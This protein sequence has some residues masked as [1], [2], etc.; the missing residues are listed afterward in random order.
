MAAMISW[1]SPKRRPVRA[2]TG[3]QF[4]F[5][6]AARSNIHGVIFNRWPVLA[7][8][9]NATRHVFPAHSRR[10]DADLAAKQRMTAI[11][12]LPSARP[13]GIILYGYIISFARIKASAIE[14]SRMQ[15]YLIHRPERRSSR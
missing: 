5:A 12:H 11:P 13:A 7:P 8:E 6:H 1:C 10:F 2:R 4:E 15:A 9:Q 14:R 3:F